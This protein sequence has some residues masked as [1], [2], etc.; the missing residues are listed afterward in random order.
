MAS[1]NEKL[2]LPESGAETLP[3]LE[4]EE[5]TESEVGEGAKEPVLRQF[6]QIGIR[7]HCIKY[8]II[9]VFIF[10]IYTVLFIISTTR[11]TDCMQNTGWYCKS[12]TLFY[13]SLQLTPTQLQHRR[14]SS[15]SSVL[16]MA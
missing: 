5:K 4:N 6:A 16:L 14:P 10:L 8:G 11:K 7:A 12:T 13:M 9:H 3:F 15:T 1:L 2:D